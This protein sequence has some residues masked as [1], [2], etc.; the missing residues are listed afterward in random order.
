MWCDLHTQEIGCHSVRLK[1]WTQVNPIRFNKAQCMVLH[2]GC[3]N[4]CY[5][6][7]L[8]YKRIGHSPAEKDLGVLTDSKLDKRQ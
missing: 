8:G 5:Q 3:G 1:Q 4:P 7:K 2:L 6:H